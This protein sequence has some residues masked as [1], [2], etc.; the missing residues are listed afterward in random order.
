M[1]LL[2]RDGFRLS[3]EV[4]GTGETLV[5]LSGLGLGSAPW[6]Q[7][8]EMLGE[9]F[10]CILIDNRG[11]GGSDTPPGP[12]TIDE[13]ADDVVAVLD[14]LRIPRASA[15]GWSMGGSIL[16]SVLSRYPDRIGR[17]VLLSALAR[18]TRTQHAW[19]DCLRAL[20]ASELSEEDRTMFGMAWSFTGKT[21]M[22][23]A[24]SWDLAQMSASLPGGAS[25]EAYEYQSAGLRAYDARPHLGKVTAEV[26]VLVGAE[27]VLTPPEQAVEIAELIPG[28][29]LK[30]LPRGSHGMLLE[31]PA[32][33]IGAMASFL[34][35]G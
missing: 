12:Y 10:Q 8:V 7:T 22:D 24:R 27:D 35:S 31:Y 1:P 13:M 18:Y 25:D 9:H 11:T 29:R 28:A 20:R 16:Q 32:E 6:E 30:V 34:K 4:R 15:V 14:S 23:H 2:N 21:L 5:L 17:A 33:T 19:L 3:Y 26:M